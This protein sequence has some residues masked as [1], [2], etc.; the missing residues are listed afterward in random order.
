MASNNK[1][2]MKKRTKFTILAMVNIIL[3]TIVV[4]A[5]SYFDKVVPGELTVAW[6][7]AWT[8]EL[9]LLFGIKV[10]SKDGRN[11]SEVYDI[12]EKEDAEIEAYNKMQDE[13]NVPEYD[14][15]LG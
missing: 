15:D 7:A 2:K 4:L 9:A 10:A 5:L 8:V 11:Y 14:P 13:E 1:K 3:Y 12:I 6:F